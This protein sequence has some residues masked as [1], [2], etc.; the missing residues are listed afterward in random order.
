[1]GV[2]A[3]AQREGGLAADGRSAG[4]PGRTRRVVDGRTA[5]DSPAVGGSAH[6]AAIGS[7]CCG[8]PVYFRAT[9]Q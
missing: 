9:G 6:T 4:R 7:F 2:M 3:A 1:M 8:A 5:R